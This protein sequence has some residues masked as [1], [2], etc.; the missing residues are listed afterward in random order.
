MASK[1][2]SN[3]VWRRRPIGTSRQSWF[4][5]STRQYR[6]LTDSSRISI[7]PN[8]P[9]GRSSMPADGST[10]R[11]IGGCPPGMGIPVSR[12]RHCKQPAFCLRARQ[13]ARSIILFAQSR[14]ACSTTLFNASAS[15]NS[16]TAISSGS[17]PISA[18]DRRTRISEFRTSRSVAA[19][20]IAKRPEPFVRSDVNAQGSFKTQFS[21]GLPGRHSTKPVQHFHRS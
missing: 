9:S 10:R 4:S 19:N 1:V 5:P 6:T 21:P 7:Q 13:I 2:Y 20:L 12:I 8:P 15:T 17:T 14:Q 16:A 3:K 11:P 18:S